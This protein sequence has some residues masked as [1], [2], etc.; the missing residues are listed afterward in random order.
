MTNTITLPRSVVEQALEALDSGPLNTERFLALQALRQSLEA[1]TTPCVCCGDGNSRL[2]VTRICD[3]CGSEYA[4]Q[5]EMDMAKQPAQ[6]PLTEEQIKTAFLNVDLFEEG[7]ELL[8]YEVDITRAIEAMH[9]IGG[10]A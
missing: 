4:G 10:E 5:A 1:D 2:S 3:A 7:D 6:Q 9:S 8:G